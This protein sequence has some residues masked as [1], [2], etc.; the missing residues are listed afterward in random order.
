MQLDFQQGKGKTGGEES[1][2][3]ESKNFT[4]FPYLPHPN[5]I[6]FI[7]IP[8]ADWAGPW[9]VYILRHSCPL[10]LEFKSFGKGRLKKL[11]I[12]HSGMCCTL[13]KRCFCCKLKPLLPLWQ[14]EGNFWDKDE[15]SVSPVSVPD[16]KVSPLSWHH[17]LKG[18]SNF[19]QDLLGEQLTTW[20]FAHYSGTGAGQRIV[21]ETWA[22]LRVKNLLFQ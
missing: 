4:F 14:V 13:S 7:L 19:Q 1:E 11:R 9:A 3:E 22:Q 21:F 10:S 17:R 6:P 12:E 20:I 8:K 16:R 15:H 18:L 2:K 5:W